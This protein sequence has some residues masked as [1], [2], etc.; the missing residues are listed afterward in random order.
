M[1]V[2]SYVEND[3]FV[4]RVT[5]YL[6]AN[7]DRKWANSYEVRAK[8]A[9]DEGDLLTLA[10]A[11]VAFEQALTLNVVL[12]DRVLISTWAPDSTP[13]DP[14]AFISSTLTAAGLVDPG[15]NQPVAL[16]VCMDV[17]R[18][19]THGRFGHLF[20]R[21]ALN[22]ADISAP[23]GKYIL[24]HRSTLQTRVDTA[25]TSSGL[26]DSVGSGATNLVLCM[27]NADGDQ[28]RDLTAL[29]VGGVSVVPFN[30]TWFNRTHITVP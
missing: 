10:E 8:V 15:A 3:K 16:N 30:H 5:K 23:A 25:L 4:F 24:D 17:R 7:P 22:E 29:Q 13:Y 1:T 21:A 19:T 6:F 27:I 26:E 2:L 14:E 9:G 18:N 28:V 12:F 11:L 20:Y